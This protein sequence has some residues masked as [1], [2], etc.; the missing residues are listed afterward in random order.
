MYQKI[1]KYLAGLFKPKTITLSQAIKHVDKVLPDYLFVERVPYVSMSYISPNDHDI[2]VEPSETR[3]VYV[4][5]HK[6]DKLKN[7]MLRGYSE[8]GEF[9]RNSWQYG[10]SYGS[11]V[12]GVKN[13]DRA[14]DKAKLKQT[15]LS[16]SIREQIQDSV[17]EAKKSAR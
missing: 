2:L 13:L 16:K 15:Y 7:E 6:M 14:I 8:F 12:I 11:N 5:R 3:E 4:Y 17:K 1:K 9:P 10:G